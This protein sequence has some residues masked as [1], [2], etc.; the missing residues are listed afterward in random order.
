M[1][2]HHPLR[3]QSLRFWKDNLNCISCIRW[4]IKRRI[5]MTAEQPKKYDTVKDKLDSYFVVRRNMIYER[6]KFNLSLRVQ[7]EGECVS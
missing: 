3:A 4:A 2:T 6:A 5:K 7:N 1:K